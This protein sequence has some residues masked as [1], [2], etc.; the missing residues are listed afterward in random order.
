MELNELTKKFE[1]HP[2]YKKLLKTIN[3]NHRRIALGGLQ[4]SAPAIHFKNLSQEIPHTFLLVAKDEEDAA[5]LQNDLQILHESE[6]VYF[7]PSLYKKAIRYGHKDAANEVIRTEILEAI[8]GGSTP[9][10]IVTYPEALIEGIV[11]KEIYEDGRLQIRVGDKVN[12]TQL[13]EK[14]WEMGF[15]EVDYVYSPG[16]FAIRGSLIDIYSYAAE[17]P[18]RLDFFDDELDSIRDFDPESQLSDKRYKEITILSSFDSD[19]RAGNS[20]IS[21]LPAE[22][23]I[24]IDQV[25]FLKAALQEVYTLGPIHPED[26]IFPTLAAI[27]KV[28]VKPEVLLE[29]IDQYTIIGT[30]FPSKEGVVEIDFSQKPEPLFHKNFELLSDSLLTHQAD[31]YQTFIMSDQQGQ[32][33]RL[34]SIFEEQ[35]KGVTFLPLRPTLH[36]GFIDQELKVALF[37]DHSIFERFHNFKL[38]SDR[39]RKNRAV[40]TLKDIQS[41][42]YG[43]YVVHMTHGIATFGGLVTLNQNGKQQETVRLN[44]KGGDSVYVSIHSLH[45]ISKYKSKDN[46]EPPQ[47]SKLGGSAWDKLKERTKKKVKDIA[48]DLIKLYAERLK[49]KGFA[50]SP[51]TYMQ[52]ELESSFM[53]EDTPDQ[54]TATKDVKSDMEKPIPMDRLICG[55]VGFGKT[56]IAIRAAFKAVADNKQVAVMVPTTVLAYQH[57]H[58]FS[59]RLKDFPCTIEYLSQGKSAKERKEILERLKEGKIDILIG[60][61]ALAGKSVVYKDLGLLIIDEEQK[62]GVTVKERL[63]RFRT[64]ID[65]LTMT[66]TP[67]PRTLQFSLMGARDLSNIQTP[68]PNRYPIRTEHTMYDLEILSEIINSELARDGQVYFI[69]NRVHNM[70]D[71]ARDIQ[72]AVPGIRI[73]I[74]HGQMPTKDLE[75]VLMDFV[76]HEYDLLLATTIVENG[77]D[78]SNANT[79]IINDAQRFGLSDLHQLRGRVGRSNHKA[80]CYLLTPPIDALTPNAKRRLQ[81]ITS[82]SEL[83]SGI[84]IAM[85]DLDIRGAGNLLGAEQSGFIADLGYETYKRILEEAVLELKAQEFSEILDDPHSESE[86]YPSGT[87]GENFVY[88]TVIETDA[89]A[90]FPQTYVPG[91]N[92][93][94]TLYRELDAIEKENQIDPYRERLQ[95][96]FGALPPEAEELLKVVQLRLLG[97]RAGVERILHRQG[98]LKLFLVSDAQSPYYRS[99]TFA[100]ILSNAARMSK[101]LQFKEEGERRSIVIKNIPSIARAYDALLQLLS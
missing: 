71:I 91:D 3:N 14:L 95:D 46:E 18:M 25:S 53:Y 93:R 57:Y 31:G 1:S 100:T 8:R 74:G 85:Q 65:T 16:E 38:K 11:K 12:R 76:N 59:K 75:D 87:S 64:H 55:D 69:H 94:I 63:R 60:T 84:H 89:E 78:V 37:T 82:F 27:Q 44:F 29:E 88:E 5:Y 21:L 47:L 10:I 26:N 15:E 22:T 4:G 67:I 68:P 99:R 98:L 7:F 39:I 40:M 13:R 23:L 33:D 51:D 80:Y 92:E 83:G 77:I 79:I 6:E 30:N 24:F 96:R 61:H 97:K 20:L 72:R 86:E 58:T 52:K 32:I 70:N 56:E 42:E 17:S 62:F 49:V 50:Y 81:S 28:L 34:R 2:A 19:E 48:R 73:G 9:K 36:Q 66:A 90:Y 54:E 43:D 35:G 41:F 45:H 101:N